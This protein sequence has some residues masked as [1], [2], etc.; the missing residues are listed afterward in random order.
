MYWWSG[1]YV[2]AVNKVKN[3]VYRW[4]GMSLQKD[5]VRGC[6][7]KKPLYGDVVT[8]SRCAGMSLQ[9]AAVR[10]CR[11]KKPVCGD[12][13]TKRRCTGM[14][15]QKAGVRGCRY[16][17]TL[18]GDVVTK[19]RC[20]GMSLQKDAVRGCRYKKPLYGHVVTK[21]QYS[22][23]P[24]VLLHKDNWPTVNTVQNFFFWRKR[25]FSP[26]QLYIKARCALL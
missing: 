10:G 13:V 22:K 6:R 23:R 9:K 16:K 21:S 20:T 25:I 5:A 14:S 8:K 11:Y 1:I 17:K 19:S 18:Y 7:Y 15:L 3:L 2:Y 4:T 24:A 12:V 26:P